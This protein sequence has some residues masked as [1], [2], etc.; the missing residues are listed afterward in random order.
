[1]DPNPSMIVELVGNVGAI[2]IVIWLVIRT[3][4]HTIPRLAKQHEDS[5]E[6]QRSDFKEIISKTSEAF[7]N[8]LEKQR[9]DYKDLSNQSRQDHLL[10]LKDHRDFFGQQIERERESSSTQN[11]EL[12]EAIKDLKNKIEK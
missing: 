8:G 2:G 4:N 10:S 5:I 9:Q 3:T 6:K 7:E 11:R 1:M 12:V